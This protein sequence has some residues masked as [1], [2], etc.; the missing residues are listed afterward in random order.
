MCLSPREKLFSV[1]FL[2]VR[3]GLSCRFGGG[4]SSPAVVRGSPRPQERREAPGRERR[5]RKR[6]AGPAGKPCGAGAARR[7]GPGPGQREPSRWPPKGSQRKGRSRPPPSVPWSR[8]RPFWGLEP[9]FPARAMSSEL[10]PAGRDWGWRR[11]EPKCS[12][13]GVVLLK[14]N[15]ITIKTNHA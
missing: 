12:S 15:K 13:A 10:G 5:R 11:K 1:L 14:G 6:R 7:K 9:P 8:C 4:C 2:S 3:V